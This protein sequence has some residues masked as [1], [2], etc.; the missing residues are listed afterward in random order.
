MAF[1]IGSKQEETTEKTITSFSIEHLETNEV[2]LRKQKWTIRKVLPRLLL[3]CLIVTFFILLLVFK[4]VTQQLMMSFVDF[5]REKKALGVLTTMAILAVITSLG[6]PFS[7][8][9]IGVGFI[10]G[11]VFKDEIW[12]AVLLGGLS[13]CIG[14][15]IGSLV[16]FVI[17]RYLLRGCTERL[18]DKYPVIKA[19]DFAFRD[20]G[21]HT[22]FLIRMC[23][24]FPQTAFNYI[25]GATS[26]TFPTYAL[27]FVGFVPT[28]VMDVWLGTTIKSVADVVQ[29]KFNGGFAQLFILIFG[30]VIAI[31]I[32]VYISY[33]VK[34]YLTEFAK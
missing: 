28:M 3:I 27:A 13:V 4:E 10:Y 9:Q 5:V 12:L 20:R 30:L 24:I 19:L 25:A 6:A 32:V 22:C 1:Q 2:T 17:G 8:T 11:M 18:I 34:A 16:P 21:F 14:N 33:R 31:V 15:W 26:L 7:L 29:G 23:P